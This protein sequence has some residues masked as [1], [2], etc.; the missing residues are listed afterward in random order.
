MKRY[1]A[2]AAGV[3]ILG[4]VAA[5]VWLVQEREHGPATAAARQGENGQAATTAA[6]AGSQ[7]NPREVTAGAMAAR[8]AFALAGGAAMGQLEVEVTGT[9]QLASPVRDGGATWQ[10]ARLVGATARLSDAAKK[11]LDLRDPSELERPWMLRTETDGRVTDVRFAPGTSVAARSVLAALAHGSQLARPADAAAKT[12]EADERDVNGPYHATYARQ[13]DG[14]IVKTWHSGPER[15]GQRAETTTRFAIKGMRP[16]HIAFDQRGTATTGGLDASKFAPFSLAIDLRWLGGADQGW[17]AGLDAKKLQAFSAAS[18]KTRHRE[19]LPTRPLEVVMSDVR[20]TAATTDTGGRTNLRNELTRAIAASDTAVQATKATLRARTLDKDAETVTIAALVGARTAAAQAAVAELVGDRALEETL[21][22][23]VLQSASLMTSPT[24]AFVAAL[25]QLATNPKD[26]AY[27]AAAATTL[28]A[29]AALLGEKHPEEAQRAIATL[30]AHAAPIVEPARK[31]TRSAQ[32]EHQP[33]G[34]RMAW[35][36]ALGN[37]GDPAAL[38]LL[39]AALDDT[40]EAVRG[41]AALALRHQDPQG[42]IGKMLERMAKDK[43]VHVRENIIDAARDMGPAVT[44]SLVEKALFYDESEFVRLAAAYALTV[45]SSQAPGLRVML[46]DA[47]KHEKS[48][49]VADA[50]KNYVDKGSFTG[51]PAMTAAQMGAHP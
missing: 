20:E 26:P 7:P 35:L 3:A 25:V 50:L 23:R 11:L 40:N 43:S 49:R 45:W 9:L 28:G 15:L 27:A 2:M 41:S 33:A 34:I 18:A 31:A 12:W 16:V 1:G 37:T 39:L 24:P 4:I 30:V 51:Q 48:P 14:A 19:A 5:G 17:A 8:Y 38:P 42:C 6:A 44:G 47:L 10:P 21:R 13:A 22:V 32:T 29:S 36:A 46:V